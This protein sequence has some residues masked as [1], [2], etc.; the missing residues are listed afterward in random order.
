MSPLWLPG[1][2]ARPRKDGRGVRGAPT[3]P[4]A[5]S[6]L[7]RLFSSFRP[8]PSSLPHNAPRLMKG[9]GVTVQDYH[10]MLRRI[11]TILLALAALAERAAD[12]S[13]SVRGLVLGILQPAE[14]VASA[15]VAET[16]LLAIEYATPAGRRPRRSRP[17]CRKIPRVRR[18]TFRNGPSDP[19]AGAQGAFRTTRLPLS[20]LRRANV[21]QLLRAIAAL[22]PRYADTS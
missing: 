15:Y 9:G 14:A 7:S 13:R 8:H 21:D 1:S 18:H 20:D 19:A 17:P 22:R 12:R 10:K 2:A 11:A 3:G 6:A 16:D 4:A 5:L